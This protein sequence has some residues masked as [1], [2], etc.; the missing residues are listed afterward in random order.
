MTTGSTGP[1]ILRLVTPEQFTTHNTT[2]VAWAKANG[3]DPLTVALK[4][5]TIEQDSDGQQLIRYHRHRTMADGSRVR[6]PH[7]T[8]ETWTVERTVPLTVPLVGVPEVHPWPSAASP[9]PPRADLLRL[10]RVLDALR[11]GQPIGTGPALPDART[12]RVVLVKPGD[13]LLIGNVGALDT[14]DVEALHDGASQLSTALGL[15]Q[16]ALFEGDIDL[17]VTTPSST[18]ADA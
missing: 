11:E 8:D 10:A 6:D 1:V 3:I 7:N 16:V 5:I 17:T 4:A 2:L 12:R 14:D 9:G 18:E 13:V 15:A